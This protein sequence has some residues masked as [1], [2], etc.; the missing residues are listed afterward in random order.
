MAYVD[1]VPC[2]SLVDTGSQVSTVSEMFLSEY[3]GNCE[4]KPLSHVD[5]QIQGA[6]GQDVPFLG[7]I[8]AEISFPEQTSGVECSLMATILVVPDTGFNKQVPLVIGTNVIRRCSEIC[9]KSY[10]KTFLQVVKPDLAWRMGYQFLIQQRKQVS[11]LLSNRRVKTSV[12]EHCIVHPNE[13]SVIWATIKTGNKGITV[14]ALVE[15][16][17]SDFPESLQ[18][19]P[20]LVSI[21][22]TGDE[23]P[24][25][26]RVH[27][28]SKD[29][30]EIVPGTVVCALQVVEVCD[31]L[32]NEK[33]DYTEE[34]QDLGTSG[35]LLWIQIRR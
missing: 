20:A 15:R 13:T 5:L 4:L 34:S 24:V 32:E 6:G 16:E 23:I 27:N 2:L 12:K 9:T 26:V 21:E 8:E 1:N 14:P 28:S 7:Y 19:M 35:P 10:G 18:I 33:V 30:I 3:L 31:T 25:P 17:N 22:M 11:K 29:D